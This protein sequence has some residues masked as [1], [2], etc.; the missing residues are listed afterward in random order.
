MV[1]TGADWTRFRGRDAAG[2]SLD[3]DLP[4]TW[5]QDENLVWKTEL[6]GFGASS[7]ITLG[8]RIFLTSYS[9]YGLDPDKPGDQADLRISIVCLDRRTG[10]RIWTAEIDPRTPEQTY[11]GFIRLHGYASGTPTTD[12]ERVYAFLGRS[13]V[14]AMTVDGELLWRTY[15][16]DGIHNWG[17]ATSPILYEDLVIVNASVE[18]ESLVALNK[19]TGAEVWRT[20]GIR[21]SWSTPLVVK[22]PGGGNELVVSLQGEILGLDPRTGKKLWECESVDD[23]VCPSVTACDGVVIVSGGRSGALTLAVRAGGRGD[24]TGTHVLW[25]VRKTPKVATPLCH[26]GYLYW[27]DQR[28]VAVCV[29]MQSG[30]V[31]YEERLDI[32]GRGDKIYASLVYGDGKLYG[33]TRQDG[34]LVMAAGPEFKMLARNDLGDS[35]VFNATPVISNGHILLRS[36][37]FLYCIGN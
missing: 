6:P 15:V 28:G 18:S 16:G 17:S 1:F 35:S 34:A 25:R 8:D 7:P 33:V 27:V 5:S 14:V 30:D 22:T 29:D 3:Q 23:Y 9:G 11:E 2:I 36:D 37:R 13:G 26:D 20:E 24:V 4:V 19:L 31:L 10:E 32:E 12:G 21:R